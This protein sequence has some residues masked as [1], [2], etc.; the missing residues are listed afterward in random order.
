MDLSRSKLTGVLVDSHEV[1]GE[2]LVDLD[3]KDFEDFFSK[4]FCSSLD[5]SLA[6]LFF[7]VIKFLFSTL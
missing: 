4:I 5:F 3:E 2:M 6:I 1:T 7:S